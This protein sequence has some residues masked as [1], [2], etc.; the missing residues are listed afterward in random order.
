MERSQFNVLF[1]C[2]GN[3]TRSI[4]AEAHLNA[5]GRGRFSAYSA[6]TRPEGRINPTVIEF[7]RE[8]GMQFEG[9]RSKS[10]DEFQSTGAPHFDY[11]LSLF[12]DD[13]VRPA[14]IWPGR[15]VAAN[16]VLAR[17]LSASTISEESRRAVRETAIAV[18][19]RIEL[20]LA[21]PNIA[22]ARMTLE[23]KLGAF[24]ENLPPEQAAARA[25]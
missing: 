22:L 5:L 9:L 10:W 15:P 11:V 18:R 12:D 13:E 23:A 4:L 16:W 21:M 6:G 25:A 3:S 2:S 14:A 20:L 19:R 8:A 24:S 7:L 17:H 1:L